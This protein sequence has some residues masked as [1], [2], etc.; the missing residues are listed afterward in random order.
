MEKAKVFFTNLSTKPG[1][2]LLDKLEA[3]VK[4][5]GMFSIDFDRKFVA[6]KIHFG[7]PGNLAYIRPNYVARIVKLIKEKG[8]YVYLTDANTLYKGRRANAVDHLQSAFE[9]GFTP[10]TTGCP[11]IIADGVKGTDYRLIEINQKNCKTAKIG[12][13]VADADIVISMN[14]FKGHELTGFGGAIKNLG[15]GSGSIGGKLEMHS[16]GQPKIVVEKCVGC[17]MCELNCAQNAIK[18][19]KDKK[20]KIDYAICV[21]CGQCV[22]VCVYDA[23][24]PRWDSKGVQEK[25]AEYALAVIKDKPSFHINFVMNVSPNCD[26]WS[27]NDIPIVPDIGIL[28]S[29]DPVAIDRA[30]VDLVNSAP[31]IMQSCI[32][33]KLNSSEVKDKFTLAQPHTDWRIGLDYAESIG[34]GTQSYELIKVD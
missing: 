20:A 19:G 8:G 14:H 23:A 25:I 5:A 18:V 4:K 2:T 11:V 1:R 34:L 22:A 7:E 27:H 17:R 15:M 31:P 28:A 30:S 33:E 24:Q 21:G 32:G 16:N 29:F 3:L 10:I 12:S 6:I 9:N 13:A 26:C